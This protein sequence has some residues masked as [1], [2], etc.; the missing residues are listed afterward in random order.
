MKFSEQ[1]LEAKLV[2]VRAQLD[3]WL[4]S[5]GVPSDQ[6]VTFRVTGRI[7]TLRLKPVRSGK[8]YSH[9]VLPDEWGK[10]LK[11]PL[12]KSQKWLIRVF[13]DAGNQLIHQDELVDFA[14]EWGQAEIYRF[15]TRLNNRLSELN[16]PYHVRIYGRVTRRSYWFSVAR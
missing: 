11:L 2:K 1:V 15:V 5:V 14:P 13:R 3:A 4:Q 8:K 6:V 7:R 16:T 10:V 9:E 12:S